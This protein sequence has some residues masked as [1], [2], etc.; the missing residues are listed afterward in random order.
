MQNEPAGQIM[1]VLP[2]V[3]F[4][5]AAPSTQTY[6]ASQGPVGP[7]LSAFGFNP[8]EPQYE[9][10]VHNVQA[11]LVT[12]PS[13]APNLPIGHRTGSE[14]PDGQYAPVGQILP[15]QLSANGFSKSAPCVQ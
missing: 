8:A 5:T 14:V 12:S 10:A 4:E 7:E 6:P 3:G 15:N 13:E 9:P 11:S 1:P 2:S